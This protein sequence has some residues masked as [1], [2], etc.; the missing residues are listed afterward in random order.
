M[1]LGDTIRK[2]PL[3]SLSDIRNIPA[4]AK[5]SARNQQLATI[6]VRFFDRHC[7]KFHL[8]QGRIEYK[9][10]IPVVYWESPL[11]LG[12]ILYDDCIYYDEENKPWVDFVQDYPF[13]LAYLCE[14]QKLLGIEYLNDI[15][16][17]KLD[18]DQAARN[19]ARG[20]SAYMIPMNLNAIP[21]EVIRIEIEET[22]LSKTEAYI[23]KKIQ[24]TSWLV[25][26]WGNIPMYERVGKKDNM[27]IIFGVILGVLPGVIIGIFAGVSWLR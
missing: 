15:A 26:Q 5:L 18:R 22:L 11:K 4:K 14:L 21:R 10:D 2:T 9:T 16:N 12:G 27:G 8:F 1:G 3:P 7:K 20:N 23:L 13:G 25:A 19:M 24:V 17:E 6:T